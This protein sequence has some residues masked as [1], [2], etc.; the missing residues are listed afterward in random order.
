MLSRSLRSSR[1]VLFTASRCF[2]SN[3]RPE[4]N[5]DDISVFA[6]KPTLELLR[7]VAIQSVCKV[8]PLV[9]NANFLINCARKVTG[10]T[11]VDFSLK[12]TFFLHFCGGT[13]M[14][15]VK[16]TMEKLDSFGVGAILDY[17]AEYD[18]EDANIA[19]ADPFAEFRHNCENLKAAANAAAMGT[20]QPYIALKVTALMTPE[21]LLRFSTLAFAVRSIFASLC[22]LEAGTSLVDARLSL[23]AL[24]DALQGDAEVAKQLFE[25]S[26]ADVSKGMTYGD[27]VM[28]ASPIKVS[29]IPSL[30]ALVME[31]SARSLPASSMLSEAEVKEA[32]QCINF[33]NEILDVASQ[34]N[35]RSLVDAEHV[36]VQAGIDWFA[37]SAM[38]KYNT[39][40]PIVMNTY[41]CYLKDAEPRLALDLAFAESKNFQ[42][43]AKIVRGAYMRHERQE[44]STKNYADPICD[45]KSATDFNYNSVVLRILD[46]V[47]NERATVLLG[48][49]NE[50][51]VQLAVEAMRVRGIQPSSDRVAFA[52][53]LGMCDNVTMKMGALGFSSYKYV[54]Y[55]PVRLVL[56]Y[57]LRRAEENSDML[58]SGGKELM[59]AVKAVGAKSPFG[60]N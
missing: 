56:P 54:P 53:L 41:Q 3:P 47:S 14:E 58:G 26:N 48:T 16:E 20:R 55:G 24:T 31:R 38:F 21:S 29:Q 8:K 17:A 5:F 42:F 10:D 7:T 13:N 19:S 57:L 35:V 12:H 25:A 18:L 43:G 59:M 2:S 50:R 9:A 34:K 49:H 46:A 33:L 45:N 27:W 32:E 60:H 22:N 23:Q 44:A 6:Q 4:V 11:L 39:T 15:E 28:S 30:G 52:Q 37:M 36:R 1:N 40:R 51:S